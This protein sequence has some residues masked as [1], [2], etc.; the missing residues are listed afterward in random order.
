MTVAPYPELL[1]DVFGPV[2]R[3]GS[4]PHT[5]GP[6]RLG[7]LAGRLLG[8]PVAKLRVELDEL[9]SFAGT[10]GIMAEDRARRHRAPA[11]SGAAHQT[12]WRTAS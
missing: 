12:Q 7:D 1:N 4:S 6:C 11:V 5:A 2:M 10:F 8:E 3:P 9:G